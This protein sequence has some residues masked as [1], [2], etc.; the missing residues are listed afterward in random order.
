MYLG[1]VGEIWGGY[2]GDPNPNPNP[3][4]NPDPN[5]NPNQVGGYLLVIGGWDG[6]ACGL[7]KVSTLDIDGLGSWYTVDVPGQSP[8]A[9]YGHSATL[10]G[11]KVVLFGGWD[12]VSPLNTVHV[13]D[14]AKL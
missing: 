12:G 8:P 3:N 10:I 4:P 6:A 5:R 14:T 7:D 11:S 13:L 1:D 9:V 2:S